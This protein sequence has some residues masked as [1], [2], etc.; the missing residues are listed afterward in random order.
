MGIFTNAQEIVKILIQCS[1]NFLEIAQK[2]FGIRRKSY[3][4]RSS[5]KS[6]WI[7]SILHVLNKKHEHFGQG[8]DFLMS[9]QWSRGENEKK[10]KR[11]EERNEAKS[12]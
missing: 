1:T 6:T 4:C 7:P 12:I 3:I 5:E 8:L 2:L 10:S 11:N 9:S